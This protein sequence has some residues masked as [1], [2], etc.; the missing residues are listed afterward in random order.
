MISLVLLTPLTLAAWVG[1]LKWWR[2][3]NTLDLLA[4]VRATASSV[5][6]LEATKPDMR[7][8]KEFSWN[9]R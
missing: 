7:D 4:D 1:F 6:A 9:R 8:H 2:Y 3:L 5:A